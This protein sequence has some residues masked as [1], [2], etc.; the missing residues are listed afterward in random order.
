M[1]WFAYPED[2][3]TT[4]SSDRDKWDKNAAAN[5]ATLVH[6]A[7]AADYV[8]TGFSVEVDGDEATVSP[9]LARVSDE[10]A[11][12]HTEGE[13]RDWGVTYAVGL[14]ES[15]TV[16]VSDGD[17]LYVAFDPDEGDG[18]S[19][20]TDAPDVGFPIAE[21]DD[22]EATP[23]NQHPSVT[24]EAASVTSSPESDEDVVR[25]ADLDDIDG[26]EEHGNEYHTDDF[27][28]DGDEQ[29]PEEHGADSHDET[30][31]TA[32]DVEAVE[33]DVDDLESDLDDHE[34]ATGDIHGIDEGDEIAA[35]SD[36]DEKADQSDV[37]DLGSDLDDHEAADSGVHGLDDTE[38]LAKTS[39]DDQQVD[40][41]ELV[42]V[43]DEFTP[44]E[45]GD[46]AHSEDYAVDGDSQPPEVHGDDD[47]DDTVPDLDTD[48]SEFSGAAGTADQILS[49]D[50][51]DA[52]WAD[53]GG[54]SGVATTELVRRN[55]N[56][57]YRRVAEHDFELGLQMIDYTGGLYDI[58]AD[59]S[60]LDSVS[61]ID[62][63]NLGS[64][65]DGAGWIELGDQPAGDLHT[66]VEHDS[67]RDVSV[68]GESEYAVVTNF[69]GS[70]RIYRLSDGSSVGSDEGNSDSYFMDLVAA[71]PDGEYVMVG[72]NLSDDR[73]HLYSWDPDDE[74]LS[75]ENERVLDSVDALAMS[76]NWNVVYDYDSQF[77]DRD[78]RYDDYGSI[79]DFSSIELDNDIESMDFG[80]D[81][82]ILYAGEDTGDILVFDLSSDEQI[83]TISFGAGDITDIS[84]GTDYM[85]V[86]TD[87]DEGVSIIDMDDYSV[88]EDDL[89]RGY[90]AMTDDDSV[91]AISGAD[92][93]KLYEVPDW[94]NP[95]E[96]TEDNGEEPVSIN[97]DWLVHE[98]DDDI[99]I[100]ETMGM[101]DSGTATQKAE[102]I[103]FSPSSAVVSHDLRE[104][105]ESTDVE[106]TL[107]DEDDN[108][109]TISVIDEEADVSDLVEGEIHVEVALSGDGVETPKLKSWA[110]YLEE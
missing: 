13:D 31:P 65:V 59:D 25:K 104:Y 66:T 24:F 56:E 18:G 23:I 105:P 37:D 58:Y 82:D 28:V 9:G 5:L 103:D 94:E 109:E 108:R 6:E 81:P 88:V 39:R 42:N 69:D 32:T 78:L 79:S 35:Q 87:W 64:T 84:V 80:D 19:L 49:T 8:V 68:M 76:Q 36:V 53:P 92:G 98:D 62:L 51:T 3:G 50:G 86:Y 21:I 101:A 45:H 70:M 20:E 60:R 52:V 110:V 14:S 95:I 83:D 57:L 99:V 27:A 107:V 96:V 4:G 10:S 77:Y 71:S 91:L 2:E 33:D 34:A 26:M 12:D 55:F 54:D 44:E 74:S 40:Y 29:P 30:V 11:E 63:S 17:T 102:E 1:T 41:D 48:V 75:D 85:A 47:H 100:R 43:P 7:N 93:L 106:Y 97:K 67:Y 72:E 38:Y 90:V 16:P 46:E 15:I 22:D 89:P 61:S 73:L